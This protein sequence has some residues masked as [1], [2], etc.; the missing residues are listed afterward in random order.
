MHSPTKHTVNPSP[1]HTQQKNQ[2]RRP[3]RRQGAQQGEPDAHDDRH[4]S[5]HGAG[6]V[7]GEGG[8][9]GLRRECAAAGRVCAAASCLPPPCQTK[10]NPLFSNEKKVW[11]GSPYN[12][13]SDLFSL[14]CVL[15]Q[16]MTYRCGAVLLFC[17]GALCAAPRSLKSP[18][19]NRHPQ[20]SQNKQ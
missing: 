19:N 11:L 4:A 8:A 10:P 13:S 17:C 6:G 18:T 5:L 20:H 1:Q 9:A 16:L 2:G 3:R 15:Y 12:T 7:C 14:G